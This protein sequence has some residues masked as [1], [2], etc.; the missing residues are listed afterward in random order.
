MKPILLDTGVIIAWLD[1]SERYH[2]QAANLAKELRQPLITCEAVVAE[3]FYL[4]RRIPQARGSIMDNLASG[5]FQIPFRLAES[6]DEIKLILR[7][8]R[9]RNIDL[10]DACLI[11]L[12]EAFD[13]AKILTL[14]RDFLFYR[15]GKN[16]VFEPLIDLR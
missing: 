5:V 7:K 6:A 14:D 4:L 3:A 9:D 8:Y 10:A 13:T 15:W 1:R 2:G 11:H 12:A 16:K